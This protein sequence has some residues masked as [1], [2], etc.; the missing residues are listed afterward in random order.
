MKVSWSECQVITRHND[1]GPAYKI[2]MFD[3]VFV[4]EQVGL[5]LTQSET[6]KTGFAKIKGAD[7]PVQSC[8]LINAFVIRLLESTISLLDSYIVGNPEDRVS[9]VAAQL[10]Q[11]NF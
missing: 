1:N 7:P 6:Q 3:L 9:R 4:A 8:K 10:Y 5:N 11:L 2:S